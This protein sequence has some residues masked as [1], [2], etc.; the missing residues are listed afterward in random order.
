M[1][2]GSPQLS[3]VQ[4]TLAARQGDVTFVRFLRN[5]SSSDHLYDLDLFPR[6][7]AT[8]SGSPSAAGQAKK[9][10]G[11]M[12]LLYATGPLAPGSSNQIPLP[13]FHDPQNGFHYGT[14]Q[15]DFS[16]ALAA[17]ADA[18]GTGDHN[19]SVPHTEALECEPLWGSPAAQHPTLPPYM[20]S[21]PPSAPGTPPRDGASAALR[22]PQP[23][24]PC[25]SVF[26]GKAETFRSCLALPEGFF[27]FWSYSGHTMDALLVASSVLPVSPVP[28]A[29]VAAEADSEAPLA[30]SPASGA[31][32]SSTVVAFASFGLAPVTWVGLDTAPAP[33]AP[34]SSPSSEGPV[35]VPG[36]SVIVASIEVPTG[37]NSSFETGTGTS[38][39]PTGPVEVALVRLPAATAG[40]APPS[41]LPQRTQGWYPK[42]LKEGAQAAGEGDFQVQSAQ[43]EWR[44]GSLLMRFQITLSLEQA[45]LVPNSTLV[46]AKGIVPL[47][48]SSSGA[49]APE[50]P[51]GASVSDTTWQQQLASMWAAPVDLSASTQTNSSSDSDTSSSQQPH[52]TVAVSGCAVALPPAS[53]LGT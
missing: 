10:T 19:A 27:L 53:R 52:P 1:I 21:P 7:S 31:T 6:A 12:W 50:A 22:K 44:D 51:T 34:E 45:Q 41:V 42:D 30:P 32:I 15:L 13:L 24:W 17:A 14:V 16:A 46:W 5:A 29:N 43:G 9:A 11:K 49:A 8:A 26:Q 38:G 47:Q 2:G 36:A 48:S 25:R 20:A 4:L 33:S 23:F 28:L 37:G 18:I 3:N 35:S 40:A 39:P